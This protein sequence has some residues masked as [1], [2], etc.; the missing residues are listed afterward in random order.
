MLLD[1]R[2]QGLAIM[3]CPLFIISS[4]Y[5]AQGF[6]LNTFSLLLGEIPLAMGK[7]IHG[8]HPGGLHNRSCGAA[9]LVCGG[10]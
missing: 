6:N 8:T 7:S 10:P 4:M 5:S 1:P 2:L 9:G 3:Q